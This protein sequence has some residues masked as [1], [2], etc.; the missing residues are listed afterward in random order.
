[1]ANIS[2][3]YNVADDRLKSTLPPIIT[4]TYSLLPHLLAAQIVTQNA[5]LSHYYT[6]LHSYCQEE[7]F[8]SPPP[9]MGTV[10]Q[11]WD[12]DFRPVQQEIETNI[13]CVAS[14]KG[15]RAPM[16]SEV[17]PLRNGYPHRRQLSGQLLGLKP[18][19]SPS[20]DASPAP[21]SPDPNTRPGILSIP[22]QTSLSLSTPNYTPSTLTS[23]SP[24]EFLTP[25]SHAPAGPRAD[26]FSR[27]RLASTSSISSIASAKKK[28]P[29]P[30]PKRF[31]SAN[32]GVWVTALYDFN[33]QG[34]GDLVFREG[35]RIRV[36]KKTESTDDWWEGELR[37]VGGSF[38]ANYC[39]GV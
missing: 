37:G 25:A 33:G 19:V 38:P 24:S 4:A 7:N 39:Q 20:I 22:S 32:Q 35:D 10:I 2:Q 29:P 27:D 26:Y 18:P 21:P 11:T 17:S 30:P 23:P 3:E 9:P 1:M 13:A 31:P 28:P 34:D 14:G 12:T 36:T 5:L 16:K 15:R 8:P 6:L